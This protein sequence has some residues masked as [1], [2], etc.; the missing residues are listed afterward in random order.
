MLRHSQR[1]PDNSQGLQSLMDE[2]KHMAAFRE[3]PA[4]SLAYLGGGSVG[5]APS[6]LAAPRSTLLPLAWGSLV[7]DVWWPHNLDAT[8]NERGSPSAS[9][10]VSYFSMS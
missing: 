7:L 8:T 6:S 4:Q 3:A 5:D 1:N 2:G 9:G 10:F